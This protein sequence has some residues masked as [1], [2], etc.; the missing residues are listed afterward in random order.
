[1]TDYEKRAFIAASG[2]VLTDHLPEDYDDP[3]WEDDDGEGIDTWVVA[4]AREPYEYWNAEQIWKQIDSVASS[5][6]SFHESEANLT[7]SDDR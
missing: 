5:L 2:Q 6:K 4:H 3:D 1:M 7:L